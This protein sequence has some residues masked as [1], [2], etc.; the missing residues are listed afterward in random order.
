MKIEKEQRFFYIVPFLLDMCVGSIIMAVPLL[1]ISLGSS[2]I[3]LGTIGFLPGI[4]YILL[5]FPFGKLSEKW[6][7][8]NLI[9]FGSFIYIVSSLILYFS[10]HLYQ[11]YLA[12]LLLGVASAMFWPTLE[13]WIAEEESKEPL[14]KRMGRFST[15]WSAG[16]AIGPFIG[17]V[18]F[19]IN[20]KLPFYFSLLISGTVFFILIWQI[21]KY[22]KFRQHAQTTQ[23]TPTIQDPP[24]TASLYLYISRV[25]NFT[26]W[27]SLGL[28]RYIF[29]KLGTNLEISPSFLGFLMFILSLSQT[30]TLYWFGKIYQWEY[31]FYP[32][33]LFQFLAFTGLILI[34]MGDSIFSFLLAFIL[35]GTSAGTTYSYSLFHSVNTPLHKGPSAAIHETVLGTGAVIG[36]L[37]GGV[38]AQQYSL[39]APY[40]LSAAIIVGGILLQIL[41]KRKY[42]F[43]QHP[44]VK[45]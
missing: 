29:P 8:K 42:K 24:A 44:K 1:A 11:V 10:Y 28:I 12:M 27:L 16:F 20:F 2:S 30:L 36:P 35:I 5:C 45:S 15:S 19:G 13:A 39:R 34:F 33:F 21:K 31:R 41:A 26:L 3:I 25:A 7:R 22:H 38:V 18:L 43:M 9:L 6:H 37:M 17:G 40:I 4:A 23:K 32:I 14:T